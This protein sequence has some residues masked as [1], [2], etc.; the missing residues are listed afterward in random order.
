MLLYKVYWLFAV[1]TDC[2]TL[3]F[4]QIKQHEKLLHVRSELTFSQR[5]CIITTTAVKM[6]EY[7]V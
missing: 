7:I 2:K 6:T 3:K 1:L 5:A 4:V